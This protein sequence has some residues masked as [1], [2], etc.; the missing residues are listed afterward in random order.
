M[1]ISRARLPMHLFLQYVHAMYCGA[2]AILKIGLTTL[3]VI[4]AGENWHS[5]GRS[6][7]RSDENTGHHRS[8]RRYPDAIRLKGFSGNLANQTFYP[9]LTPEAGGDFV[10][11]GAQV[12]GG[13]HQNVQFTEDA[14]M[15]AGTGAGPGRERSGGQ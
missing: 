5:G 11:W 6:I 9:G 8:N 3:V 4:D 12:D 2:S 1:D 10:D 15:M 14:V 7:S 13:T